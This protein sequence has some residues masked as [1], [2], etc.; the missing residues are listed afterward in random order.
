[1][2]TTPIENPIKKILS[3][4][5]TVS[6]FYTAFE[7]KKIECFACGHRCILNDGKDGICKVRFNRN[8]KLF[9][10]WGYV[11]AIQLDPIEKKPFY[12]ILPG[13]KALSFGMLGCDLHCN[14]CQNW[15]TSQ[16]LRDK[17]S[18]AQ[19]H[20][21]TA[22]EINDFAIATRAHIVTS[23]YNEP[24]ITSEWA[25]EIF[26]LAKKNNLL[27][28]YVSNGNTT[29]E[30]LELLRP[31]VDLFKVDL[32][33]FNDKYYRK[34]GCPLKNILDSIQRLYEMKFWI[35][36]VTLIV[37]QFNDSEIEIREIAKFIACVSPDIPWHVTAFHP[38]YK[39]KTTEKTSVCLLQRAAEIGYEEGLHFV[40]TG[41]LPGM[42]GNYE[43]TYCYQCKELLVERIGFKI[44][45]NNLKNNSCPKCSTHIPGIWKHE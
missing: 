25:I 19:V 5:T 20:N 44:K 36:I 34:L 1:M 7:N 41:N 42:L 39:M 26:K 10:P 31:Y 29:P 17:N 3:K 45:K 11:S 9:V 8:G 28:S 35:E 2:E 6:N 37:P 4:Y 14:Y 27:T 24:L 18:L 16:T 23:T 38:D 15:I 43:N 22:Q 33:G 21:I 32:K 13:E 12:H 40:Y 30:I